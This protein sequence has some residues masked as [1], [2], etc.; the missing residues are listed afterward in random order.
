MPR[1]MVFAVGVA[2]GHFVLPWAIRFVTD[3][4]RGE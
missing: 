4:M 3:K 2:V 1:V